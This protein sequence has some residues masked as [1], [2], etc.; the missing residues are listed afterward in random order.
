MSPTGYYIEEIIEGTTIIQALSSVQYGRKGTA[1]PD[2]GAD[3]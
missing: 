1:T 2:E 3:G